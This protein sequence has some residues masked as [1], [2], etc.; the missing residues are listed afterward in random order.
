MTEETWRPLGV[1]TDEEIA[2]YDALH[3]GVPEWM[4]SAMWAWVRQGITVRRR[5]P[6]G[7]GS[8]AMLDSAL[9]ERMCQT[10]RIPLPTLR[11]AAVSVDTGHRHLT[12]AMTALHEHP[13]P[14]QIVDYLLAHGGHAKPDE[15]AEVLLCSRSAWEVGERA[16]RP[17]LARRV[18]AGVQVAADSVMQRAGRAGAR[19]AKAWEA[20]Y[21]IEPNS[22][23]AYR[24]AI[25]AVEDAAVSV[26]SPKNEKA[27]LGTILR[28]VEQQGDWRLPMT[29]EHEGAPSREVLVGMIR[30]LWHGQHDRH[31]G[32]PSAPGDVSFEEASVAVSLAVTLVQW[33]GAGLLS[34][35][36]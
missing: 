18:P 24:L 29:R 7:S 22:S 14:L 8:V 11:A 16:G 26:V 10:L 6:D 19:L 27:T 35:E 30:L 5:Y 3:D 32:Q 20:L 25:L 2:E 21:G 17:G 28:D 31:G 36:R 23:E 13:H 15:L 33:F 4:S 1:G 12:A 9:A 34:R